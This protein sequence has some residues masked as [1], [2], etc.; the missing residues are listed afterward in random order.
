MIFRS[1]QPQHYAIFTLSALMKPFLEQSGLN[2]KAFRDSVRKDRLSRYLLGMWFLLMIVLNGGYKSKM[3][4]FVVMPTYTKLLTSFEELAFSDYN[5][6]AVIWA[7]NLE[8]NFKSWNNS[9][10]RVIVDRA[11]ERAPMDPDVSGKK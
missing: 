4:A 10:S 6:L 1:M 3:T 11:R 8:N 9:Y 2:V 5:L 7:D